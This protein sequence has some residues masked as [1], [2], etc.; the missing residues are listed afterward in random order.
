MSHLRPDDVRNPPSPVTNPEPRWPTAAHPHPPAQPPHDP[1]PRHVR[2]HPQPARRDRLGLAGR[3]PGRRRAHAPRAGRIQGRPEPDVRAA[4]LGAGTPRRLPAPEPPST[5]STSRRSN[6][7]ACFSCGEPLR[8]TCRCHEWE[9]RNRIA[10][11]SAQ[12]KARKPPRNVRHDVLRQARREVR[13]AD[14]WMEWGRKARLAF[15]HAEEDRRGCRLA[16][17]PLPRLALAR[18]P[19]EALHH[20]SG[21]NVP[22]PAKSAFH[23]ARGLKG[24]RAARAGEGTQNVKERH[25]QQDQ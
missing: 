5:R 10:A 13:S 18:Y 8:P 4:R 7:G 1:A 21:S 6:N 3:F 2:H 24:W 12:G 16:P 15:G 20:R 22:K 14:F 19:E 25:E 17:C 11:L 9:S 23:R